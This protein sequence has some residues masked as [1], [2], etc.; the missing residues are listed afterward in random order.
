MRVKRSSLL[1]EGIVTLLRGFITS[2]PVQW[3]SFS[4]PFDYHVSRLSDKIDFISSSALVLTCGLYH[5]SHYG[6]NLRFP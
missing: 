2:A 1:R 6:C 3:G 4:A 5:K